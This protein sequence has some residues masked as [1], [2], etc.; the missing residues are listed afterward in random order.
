MLPSF[1]Q[2]W[3]TGGKLL[4][5]AWS[6]SY[7]KAFFT[8]PPRPMAVGSCCHKI[9]MSMACNIYLRHDGFNDLIN[10]KLNWA[11]STTKIKGELINA[12]FGYPAKMN[13]I[14]LPKKR[15]SAFIS[16]ING[17]IIEYYQSQMEKRNG[18]KCFEE[19]PTYSQVNTQVDSRQWKHET[20]KVVEKKSDL[21]ADSH[22]IISSCIQYRSLC[23]RNTSDWIRTVEI[24]DTSLRLSLVVK[25]Q[26]LS[27]RNG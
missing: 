12:L 19:E 8:Y 2:G 17:I 3:S 14:N 10:C 18:L 16:T 6:K 25:S 13:P 20:N 24:L 27:W 9:D 5:P 1:T 23:Q 21:S 26:L 22:R 15:Q 7:T 4:L 11:K